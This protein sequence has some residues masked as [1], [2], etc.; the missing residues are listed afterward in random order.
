MLDKLDPLTSIFFLVFI[1]FL[2]TLFQF[3]FNRLKKSYEGLLK[4]NEREITCLKQNFESL[5]HDKKIEASR[6]KEAEQQLRNVLENNETSTLQ[7]EYLITKEKLDNC[8]QA[9]E[10]VGRIGTV[11]DDFWR[12]YCITSYKNI[13]EDYIKS[14]FP[15]MVELMKAQ[16]NDRNDEVL[17]RVI[18]VN[19]KTIE[20]IKVSL[21]NICK[22]ILKDT[23]I[24]PSLVDE[25]FVML[26]N[27]Y[28]R[29]EEYFIS[30]GPVPVALID[31]D[32]V[33]GDIFKEILTNIITAEKLHPVQ[34][35]LILLHLTNVLIYPLSLM[36]EQVNQGMLDNLLA[37][38]GYIIFDIK[39]QNNGNAFNLSIPVA[40]RNYLFERNKNFSKD[41]VNKSMF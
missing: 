25:M 37:N 18:P 32:Y 19:M 41:V 36:Q 34:S 7:Q 24:I 4:C 29:R 5:L 39:N 14:I 28:E 22:A 27:Y 30:S 13:V 17:D 33:G 16:L 21:E 20:H 15:K 38:T 12:L 6:R 2:I 10:M 40:A 1:L 3:M 26:D 11:T 31:K 23:V 9:L 35:R 8:R